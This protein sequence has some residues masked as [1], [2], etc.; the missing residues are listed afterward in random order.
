MKRSK[1]TGCIRTPQSGMNGLF[2]IYEL[3][4]SHTI[5][6]HAKL[7]TWKVSKHQQQ[8]EVTDF[9]VLDFHTLFSCPQREYYQESARTQIG[10]LTNHAQR[11]GEFKVRQIR[12]EEVFRGV[13]NKALPPGLVWTVTWQFSR[14]PSE[15]LNYGESVAK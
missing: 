3:C 7:C 13:R 6:K 11:N 2:C 15:L 10:I 4:S 14:T 8:T 9:W 12:W 1:A 5:G